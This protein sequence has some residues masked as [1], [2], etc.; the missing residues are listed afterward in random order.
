MGYL[1]YTDIIERMR[2]AA[3][4]KND[5]SAARIL[6]ITPQALSNYK[7]RGEMPASLIIKF[8]GIYG[9]SVDWLLT[10]GGGMSRPGKEDGLEKNVPDRSKEVIE[11]Q[12]ITGPDAFGL[13]EIIYL[14]KLLKILR[15][16]DKGITAG[17]KCLIDAFAKIIETEAETT[18]KIVDREK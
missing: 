11:F 8:A 5:S 14:S 15:A 2:W 17:T 6:G 9:L 18:G 4:L 12:R 13:D 7:K 16:S 1:N 10:G 3:R